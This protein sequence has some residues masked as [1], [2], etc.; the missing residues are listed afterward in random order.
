MTGLVSPSYI[1]AVPFF[2][3]PKSEHAELGRMRMAR[4]KRIFFTMPEAMRPPSENQ[5]QPE[6]ICPAEKRSRPPPSI[7]PGGLRRRTFRLGRIQCRLALLGRGRLLPAFVTFEF[8]APL[9]LLG[10]A[11]LIFTLGGEIPLVGCPLLCELILPLIPEVSLPHGLLLRVLC[12]PGFLQSFF[13]RDPLLENLALGGG[14][15][16]LWRKIS[17]CSGHDE[18]RDG[19]CKQDGG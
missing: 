4:R 11:A 7:L 17:E 3:F 1:R 8:L 12:R 14:L 10:G 16:L 2:P 19:A 9:H 6:I 18:H 13:V 15:F 5:T